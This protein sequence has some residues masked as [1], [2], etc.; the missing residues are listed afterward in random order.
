MA[1]KVVA[2]D[3]QPG[4]QRDGTVFDMNY[5]TDGKWVRFQRGRPRKVGGYKAITTGAHGYS[6]GVYVNSTAGINQVF[7][8]YN[9]GLEVVSI[10]N[11][12]IGAGITQFTLSNFTASNLNLWQFDGFYD[13]GGSGNGLLLGHPGQNLQQID[14]TNT[15][16]VLIG[17]IAGTSLSAIGVFTDSNA[18]LNGTTTVTLSLPDTLIGAGQIVTGTGIAANTTVASIATAGGTLSSV[19]VTG[20]SGTF[21]CAPTAGLYPGQ[22]VTPSGSLGTNTLA[23]VA[24]TGTS[25]TF[26]CTATTGLYVNQPVA[27]SGT[28]ATSTL[29]GVAI[30]G[31]SGTFSCTATTGLAVGQ[32][33]TVTG[34]YGTTTLAG[35][36]ITGLSGTF[37]CTATTG[38][39][40]GQPVAVQGTLAA[41]TIATVAV[42]GLAGQCSVTPALT[43]A[44]LYI[45]MAIKV[46]GTLTGTATGITTNTIYYVIA[47]DGAST[48]TLSA[49]RGGTAITTTVGTTT[50]LTFAANFINGLTSGT[51][52]YIIVTNGTSTFTLSDTLNGQAITTLVASVSGL[53]FT[54]P[55]GVGINLGAVYYITATNGTSTF[56]LSATSGGAALTNTYGSVTGLTFKVAPYSG[57]TTG[58]TYYITVTNGTST[59]T[60]S[61]TI[62]GAALAT[63]VTGLTGLV[64]KATNYIG[65]TPGT[66]YYIVA[67]NYSTTFTLSASSGGPPIT[68]VVNATTGFGFALGQYTAVVLSIA[69]TMSGNFTLTFDNSVSVSGGVCVLHPY[70]FV[71]G[72]NGLLKN[73]SAGNA[74]DWVSADANETNVASTKIVKGL[75]VRGGSNA[76]SGLF[77]A[78]DSVIRVS[79]APTSTGSSTTYWRYDIVSSQSSILSSQS[80]I[81][82]DGIYFWC[83]VDRFLMYNGVVKEVP[84]NFNQNY[85]FDNLNYA[86]R[87]KVWAQKVPRF[88]EIWWFY[89]SGTST[90]CNDAI[91]YNVRDNVWYDAG[92]ALGAQRSAGYFSQVFRF[93]INMGT[94]LSTAQ[95]VFATTIIT[96]TTAV[97]QVPITNQIALSQVVVATGVPT[98]AQVIAIAPSA[99][100]GY[101]A[102]TLSIAAIASATVSATF[103]T[104]AGLV[105]MWQHEIGVDAVVGPTVNAIES[106]FE[107]SD[108]GL[109]SGG[110]AQSL[111][112]GDNVWERIERVEPDFIQSG[113][114]A[115]RITG[116]PYAQADDVVSDPYYFEPGTHKIDMREQRREIR[117]NF[118]SNVAGGDYQLGK[119]LLSIDMGDVRGY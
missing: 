23:G 110:P 60:L 88:G 93:P 112:V 43:N 102:V 5:Y 113:T 17:N 3:T 115:L 70:V 105:T 10:N 67:T 59:F 94:E 24:I 84:N 20:T 100:P 75:P 9:N 14:S 38:L 22:T 107:T 13:A 45:G 63:V 57:L 30:T 36:A 26:S 15:T 98:G 2:I 85:F 119:L 86:Q 71:Y 12:G 44:G 40:V 1:V 103:N 35:V 76:P 11:L 16:P 109:V 21:S 53:T 95:I 25:G 32:P 111:L 33:M 31:S 66:V 91:I 87:Q 92:Q 79:Y 96:N 73:C 19:A 49:T 74:N 64:F 108:I 81:E 7:N 8:G 46:T 47:T 116:R 101:Y 62:G 56:T 97:I 99:T 18:Y 68:T 34:S 72:D 80:I 65:L 54:G 6:R 117:L 51:T 41:T 69:A 48:F 106:F 82:Y 37:S 61:D 77:W 104:V 28:P 89:P 4:V 118:S 83:G 55:N 50:G 27:V 114:M 78:L 39:Y 29:A 42:T 58:T 90:E 52:Y